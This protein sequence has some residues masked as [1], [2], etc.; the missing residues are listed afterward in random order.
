MT[1][2]WKSSYSTKK[3]SEIEPGEVFKGT[4]DVYMKT[5]WKGHEVLYNSIRLSDGMLL[6]FGDDCVV[7]MLNVQLNIYGEKY[8]QCD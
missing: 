4:A 8:G 1:I 5:Q 7:T 3:F 6:N 2:K